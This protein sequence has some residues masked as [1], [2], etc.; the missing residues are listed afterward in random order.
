MFNP[1]D[2]VR[3]GA[4]FSHCLPAHSAGKIPS[5]AREITL[6]PHTGNFYNVSLVFSLPS[7]S[8]LMKALQNFLWG[9]FVC[10]PTCAAKSAATSKLTRLQS[11]EG[12]KVCIEINS[13][14]KGNFLFQ[15]KKN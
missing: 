15:E 1:S 7:R 6:E 13:G 5:N 8:R 9:A 10:L 14:K 11:A 3:H 2:F 12:H 4:K